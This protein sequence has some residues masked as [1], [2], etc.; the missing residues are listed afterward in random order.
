ML[1]VFIRIIPPL[2]FF[3]MYSNLAFCDIYPLSRAMKDQL[4]RS[5]TPVSTAATM[6]SSADTSGTGNNPNLL[7]C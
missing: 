6:A 2:L 3:S 5:L 1:V 7:Y 4:Y